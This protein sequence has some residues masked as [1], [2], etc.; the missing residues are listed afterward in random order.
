MLSKTLLRVDLKNNIL[1]IQLSFGSKVLHKK[2]LDFVPTN[3]LNMNK[4]Y[5]LIGKKINLFLYFII[6]N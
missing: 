5:I 1:K 6:S 4:S 3:I 2:R